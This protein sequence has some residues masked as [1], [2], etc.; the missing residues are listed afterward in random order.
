MRRDGHLL[1]ALVERRQ[2]P[3]QLGSLSERVFNRAS[4]VSSLLPDPLNNNNNDDDDDD[5]EKIDPSTYTLAVT[6]SGHF[7]K[8][9]WLLRPSVPRE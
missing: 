3:H 8:R 7:T 6:P 2:T 1:A 5:D 4:N 9:A